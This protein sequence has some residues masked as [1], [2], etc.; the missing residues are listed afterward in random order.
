[1]AGRQEAGGGYAVLSGLVFPWKRT[2]LTWAP[3]DVRI[4]ASQAAYVRAVIAARVP[5][6]SQT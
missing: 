5:T 6:T 3:V 4:Y 1:M 2:G